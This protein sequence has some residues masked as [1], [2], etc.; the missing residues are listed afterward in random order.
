MRTRSSFPGPSIGRRP[1]MP[2]Q[3]PARRRW[4]CSPGPARRSTG[5]TTVDLGTSRTPS[6]TKC[7]FEGLPT[8]QTPES[9]RSGG[10][11]SQGWSR[12][13]RISRTWASPWWN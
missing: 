10:A 5:A 2:G 3:T 12:R 6:F 9:V 8:T 11:L 13:S 4:A 1:R 7:T